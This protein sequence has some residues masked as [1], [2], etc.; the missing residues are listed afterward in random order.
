MTED[1]PASGS[2]DAVAEH[3]G[4]FSAGTHTEFA[5]D[6]ADVDLDGPAADE[7]RVGDL[8]V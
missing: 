5:E 6:V 3:A 1:N 2:D 8:R 7:E 4:G